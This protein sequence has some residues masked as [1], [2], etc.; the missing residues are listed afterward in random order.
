MNS[1]LTK[2]KWIK[3]A[4]AAAVVCLGIIIIILACLNIGQI[5]NVIDIVVAIALMVF[6]IAFICA[7]IFSE[8][9]ISITLSLIL[10]SLAITGVIVLLIGRFH[11]GINLDLKILV[12]LIGVFSIVF[13]GAC[14][15]KAISMIYYR[16][17]TMLVVLMFALA[18]VAIT[19]GILSIVFA[20]NLV[21]PAYIILGI[22]FV[23]V[24]IIG[25]V[26]AAVGDKKKE[27]AD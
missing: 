1:L 19:A 24:G 17:K 12:Y 7:S 10:G 2:Y 23:V 21:T 26:L 4:L 16:Q 15:F 14:I 9:H 18:T 5:Q 27:K 11:L 20:G 3:Y 6:G 25:I 22:I 8:T 13:G